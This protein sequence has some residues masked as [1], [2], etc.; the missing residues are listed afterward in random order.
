MQCHSHQIAL[1][2]V[3]FARQNGL[4]FCQNAVFFLQ[5]YSHLLYYIPVFVTSLM[6][7]S[8]C[9][10]WWTPAPNESWQLSWLSY[11]TSAEG[12]S[13][14]TVWPT[15]LVSSTCTMASLSPCV[16]STWTLWLIYSLSV[17][18]RHTYRCS[19]SCVTQSTHLTWFV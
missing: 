9:V 2:K 17:R 8:S 1:G 19:S 3:C 15:Y 13:V 4:Q 11:S 18:C 6:T 7:Q 16:V 14:A 10:H 12:R 5:S